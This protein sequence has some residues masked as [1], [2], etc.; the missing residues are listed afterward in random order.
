MKK[1]IFIFLSLLFITQ[2]FSQGKL[3]KSDFIALDF[4]TLA[5]SKIQIAN[6]N[7]DFMPA[8]NNLIGNCNKN[9]K[10]PLVSVMDKK[11]V[12]PSGDKHDYMSLAP[13]WWPDPS[14]Q[15]GVP[16][17]RKDG[18]VNPEVN[19]YSDKD[20]MPKLCEKVYELSLGFYFSN[21]EKYA[22]K[23]TDIIRV[24]FLNSET[25]MNPN[26][27][28]AQ[29]VKGHDDGRGAGLI[30]TRHFIFLLDGVKLLKASKSWTAKDDANLKKWFRA[31]YAWL[32]N[33][34][35]GK[36]EKKTTNNHGI[37]Y[38][39]QTLAIA[40][41]LDSL[42]ESKM[43]INRS[44][45]RLKQ[46]M[47]TDGAFP[48]ELG[49]TNS[50]HYSAFVLNAFECVAQLSDNIGVDFRNT[51][52]SNG[53]SLKNAYDFLTPYLLAKKPWTW[54]VLK[55]FETQNGYPLLVSAS[56]HNNCTECITFINAQSVD[57]N[58]LILKLL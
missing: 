58:Q 28:F 39:A 52:L 40:N 18:E 35:N 53:M 10:F 49:R 44:L 31:Y 1:V 41:Y 21:N 12:P 43:I 46:Q 17:M 23:A 15:G 6:K 36:D 8:Y 27:N 54:P 11:D 20:N 51:Q 7:Q 56:K 4:K 13:Y 38:D 34:K 57:A 16:Y 48:E 14:K 33:S 26:L 55:H 25:K 45:E 29:A 42:E 19:N 2:V 24:W 47:N 37:W 3:S 9:L 5:I 32:N 30:D 50:L 22:K